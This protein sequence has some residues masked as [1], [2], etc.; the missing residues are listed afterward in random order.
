MR[1]FKAATGL[2]I[3]FVELHYTA[4]VSHLADGTTVFTSDQSIN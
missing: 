1:V 2:V 4:I 3:V